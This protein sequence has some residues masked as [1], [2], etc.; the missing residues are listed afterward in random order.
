MFNKKSVQTINFSKEVTHTKTFNGQQCPSI[1]Q[2]YPAEEAIKVWGQPE[3]K[4][5]VVELIVPVVRCLGRTECVYIYIFF[6]KINTRMLYLFYIC[7][8][9]RKG[10]SYNMILYIE[11]P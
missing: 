2:G 3:K 11:I 8:E 10:Q 1:N 4:G 5:G 7:L 9:N 6:F